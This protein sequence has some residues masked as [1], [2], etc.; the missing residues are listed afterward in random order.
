MKKLTNT[1]NTQ[2]LIHLLGD[3]CPH[4][5]GAIDQTLTTKTKDDTHIIGWQPGADKLDLRLR[6]H[7]VL[8]HVLEELSS[9]EMEFNG[10]LSADMLHICEVVSFLSPQ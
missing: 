1:E 7:Y 6:P 8:S 5:D 4:L 3:L 9:S 2:L 10:Q